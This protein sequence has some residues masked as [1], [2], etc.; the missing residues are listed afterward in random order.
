MDH[1]NACIPLSL[2]CLREGWVCPHGSPKIDIRSNGRLNRIA[3]VS[4]PRN[5]WTQLSLK[6][7]VKRKQK[8]IINLSYR[9]GGMET[10]LKMIHVTSV[11]SSSFTSEIFESQ[12]NPT[13]T[14]SEAVYEKNV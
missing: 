4:V 6:M 3:K 11:R 7:T 12:Q 10:E 5:L 9:Y 1:W 13:E 14:F 2:S 8:R